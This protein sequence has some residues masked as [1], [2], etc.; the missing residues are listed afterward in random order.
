MSLSYPHTSEQNKVAERKHRHI[1]ET[2][3]T[4]LAQ[5]NLPM[6]YWGYAFYSSIHIT[7]YLPTQVLKGQSFY[8]V[9]Y[10]REPTYDNL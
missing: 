9:F 10:G 8:Q 2:G 6:G 3:L 1:V 7:N 4:I 5:S